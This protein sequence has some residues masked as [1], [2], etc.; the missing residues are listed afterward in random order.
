MRKAS[1]RYATGA[2]LRAAG[3]KALVICS[4]AGCDVIP[5]AFIVRSAKLRSLPKAVPWDANGGSG[6]KAAQQPAPP[7]SLT[8][9]LDFRQRRP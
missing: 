7:G 3:L 5:F 8:A 1:L 4:P 9:K 2:A 6:G